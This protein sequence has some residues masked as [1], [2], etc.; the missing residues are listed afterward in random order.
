M[1]KFSQYKMDQYYEAILQLRPKN[2][3]LL[4]YVRNQILKNNISIAKEINKKYGVDLYLSSRKFTT[5]LARKLKK[6]FKG[7]VKV[8]RSLYTRDRQT[9]KEVY[10]ITI[11][12]RLKTQ[13]L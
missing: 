6:N 7:T 5:A 13:N 4:D 11:L 2:K 10:R 8:S 1:P 9:S 3:E 12:F